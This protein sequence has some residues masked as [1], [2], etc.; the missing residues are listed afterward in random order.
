MHPMLRMITYGLLG[1]FGWASLAHAD[2]VILVAGG[3]TAGDGSQATTAKLL[4]PF[5]VGFDGTGNLYVVEYTGQ[6][7]RRIDPKGIISTV[8]GT[9]QKGSGGAGGPAIKA[10]LNDPNSLSV[11]LTGDVRV[12]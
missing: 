1:S 12:A 4:T 10:E 11:M 7:V 6:R 3:G 8:A 2:K 9:G 5:G